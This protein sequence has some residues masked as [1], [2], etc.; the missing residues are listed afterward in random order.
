MNM[1]SLTKVVISFLL[2]LPQ[3]MA[4][5]STN[6][7]LDTAH[8]RRAY[9]KMASTKKRFLTATTE[10]DVL[11]ILGDGLTEKEK[12]FFTTLLNDERK[13]RG[14][15][16][17]NVKSVFAKFQFQVANDGKL[18]IY[19][20]GTRRATI[21]I[22]DFSKRLVRINGRPYEYRP[23]SSPV[24]LYREMQELLTP[25]TAAVNQGHS[26]FSLLFG[27]APAHAMGWAMG[28]GLVL[29]GYAATAFVNSAFVCPR[30]TETREDREVCNIAWPFTVAGYAAANKWNH[31]RDSELTEKG[32][33]ELN[34]SKVECKR[35]ARPAERVVDSYGVPLSLKS[36]PGVATTVARFTIPKGE[37]SGSM[38]IKT[39]ATPPV[40]LFTFD[41]E[42]NN[43]GIKSTVV[44]IPLDQL[45]DGKA[46][47]VSGPLPKSSERNAI[48]NMGF[49]TDLIEICKDS[50]R[51]AKVNALLGANESGV[52]PDTIRATVK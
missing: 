23:Y 13:E 50:E 37:L 42:S 3:A 1:S 44:T 34:I 17:G 21:E 19:Q 18:S 5:T 16:G 36:D 11:D 35:Q 38:E 49:A 20:S 4:A 22:V 24:T 32:L 33:L 47:D 6:T 14:Q 8:I 29:L 46:A 43:K 10:Q 52:N 28:T 39:D 7:N 48:H 31:T 12:S 51:L 41:D 25:Q 30:I 45:K 40:A 27:S 26:P 9:N 15:V 2:S